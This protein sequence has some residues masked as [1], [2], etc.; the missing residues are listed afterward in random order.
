V[1]SATAPGGAYGWI[2]RSW[3]GLVKREASRWPRT[4][5]TKTF[6]DHVPWLGPAI[7][8]LSVLYFIVQVVVAQV[9]TPAYS[10]L[11]NTIS[12][13]GN[14]SCGPALCSPRHRLMNG[15]LYLLGFVMAAG[16][17]LIF[18]EFTASGPEER[19]AA[20]IGFS[21]LA[22]GGV[23]AVLVGLFP[24]NTV[25]VLHIV[26]AGMAIF[27]GT[28]G[29][30]VLGLVLSLPVVL[31]WCMRV[32]GPLAMIAIVLFAFHVYLGVGAGT[33]ERLAAYPETIWLFVFGIYISATDHYAKARP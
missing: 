29:I 11:N 33:V 8:V 32:V 20:R 6:R 7:Y 4:T 17:L 16:S 1:T 25:R 28:L 30:F 18:Q 12:D 27:V 14:T 24:E 31:R 3:R 13:L 22:V 19:L 23:G 2:S 9:W 15:E 10:W 26:G 21:F 5:R